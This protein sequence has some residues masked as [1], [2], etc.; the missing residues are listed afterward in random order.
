MRPEDETRIN[1]KKIPDWRT[2][3][4]RKGKNYMKSQKNTQGKVLTCS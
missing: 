1:Q 3:E 2:E 4:G